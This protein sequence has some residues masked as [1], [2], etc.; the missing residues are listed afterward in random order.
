VFPVR[1]LDPRD[2]DAFNTTLMHATFERTPELTQLDSNWF[3]IP[4][5]LYE[6]I[7]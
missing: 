2:G 4:A 5:E 7:Q 3:H 1:A 6:E